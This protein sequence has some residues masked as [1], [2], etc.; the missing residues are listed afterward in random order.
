MGERAA[1]SVVH[2]LIATCAVIALMRVLPVR[3]RQDR[4]RFWLLALACPVVMSPLFWLVWPARASESFRDHWALFSGARLS[5]LTVSGVHPGRWL[6]LAMMMAGVALFL[7]DLGPFVLDV[8]RT[9]SGR[10]PDARTPPEL[11]AVVGHV[12]ATFHMAPPRLRVVDG[13]PLVLAC[14]GVLRPTLVIS[15]RLTDMLSPA[16]LEASLAHEMA[17]AKARD[18]LLGWILMLIRSAFFFN[19][20]VQ[21]A[22]RAAVIEIEHA[23]D[24]GA[25]EHMRDAQPV[26]DGLRRLSGMAAAQATSVSRWR[27]LRM[28]AIERR[29]QSLQALVPGAK[30]VHANASLL[31][32][33]VGLGVILFLTVV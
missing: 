14:R 8:V 16:A 9:R 26:I 1:E 4:L 19:P 13:S 18:P 3:A 7:R 15:L 28:A 31:A 22:A 30:P 2:G 32:T 29:C 33:T 17:H 24:E 20:M 11:S 5:T 23:A 12:A 25:A 10:L 21:L 6:A 27:V